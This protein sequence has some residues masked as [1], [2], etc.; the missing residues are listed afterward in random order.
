V[1]YDRTRFPDNVQRILLFSDIQVSFFRALSSLHANSCVPPSHDPSHFPQT[2]HPFPTS[3][4]KLERIWEVLVAQLLH[5][6]HCSRT[7]V[8]FLP[9]HLHHL[10]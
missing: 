2:F 1:L 7:G 4:R 10:P 6:R 8:Q 9:H 3:A 5:L